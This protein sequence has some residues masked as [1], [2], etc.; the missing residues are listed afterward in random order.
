MWKLPSNG[1]SIDRNMSR[2]FETDVEG[3][4]A[5]ERRYHD[6]GCSLQ[7]QF[8]RSERGWVIRVQILA[9]SLKNEDSTFKDGRY[10]RVTWQT[11]LMPIYQMCTNYLNMERELEGRIELLVSGVRG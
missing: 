8:Q 5:C 1:E 2:R 9:E 10:R 4:L 11:T 7:S 6:H 3:C